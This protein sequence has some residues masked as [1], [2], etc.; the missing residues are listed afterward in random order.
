MEVSGQLHVLS[1]L[2]PIKEFPVPKQEAE[3]GHFRED[4]NFLPLPD[5]NALSS[6]P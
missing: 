5:P 4:V 3:V 2:P 6:S 1:T